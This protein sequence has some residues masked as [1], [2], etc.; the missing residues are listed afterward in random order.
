MKRFFVLI[1][2]LFTLQVNDAQA[3]PPF[4]A[5]KTIE[6]MEGQIGDKIMALDFSGALSVIDPEGRSLSA[7]Q[8]DRFVTSLTNFF[9][10]PLTDQALMKE[11]ILGGGFRRAI[12]VYWRDSLP[13]YF[14]VVSHSRGDEVW[15]LQYNID[16]T[17][18][19][20]IS[21]F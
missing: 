7:E 3:A 19:K 5:F 21:Q 6:D 1:A 13:I 10:E 2:L 15:L 11:E 9:K 4:G 18:S 14:Y 20:I 17:F 16:T 8:K 12:Y